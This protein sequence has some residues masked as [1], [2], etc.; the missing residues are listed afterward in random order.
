LHY[1]TDLEE[2]YSVQLQSNGRALVGGDF[3]TGQCVVRRNAARLYGDS[4]APSLS[5]ARWN[6]PVIISWPVTGSNF[7]LQETTNLSHPSFLN[8]SWPES[9]GSYQC[10]E[11]TNL[12]SGSWSA[13]AQ[14]AVTNDGQISVTIPT[15]TGSKFFRLKSQ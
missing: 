15:T 9:A 14:A 5:L 13:I 6:A 3:T 2:R 12:S 11:S 4:V 1:R 7:Q 10:E 8:I